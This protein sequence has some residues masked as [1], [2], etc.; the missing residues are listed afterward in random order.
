MLVTISKRSTPCE[1]ASAF[2][3]RI[4][5][6]EG[7]R[8]WR[9]DDQWRVGGG[10]QRQRRRI[11][12][13]AGVD[14][15]MVEA[16]AVRRQRVE[17]PAALGGRKGGAAA[18]A[19]MARREGQASGTGHD[20]L[21]QRAAAGEHVADRP[22]RIQSEQD[23][24]IGETHV[25]IEQKRPSARFGQGDGEIDAD[26]GLSDAALAARDGDRAGGP[27]GKQTHLRYLR[28]KHGPLDFAADHGD[29]LDGLAV[30]DFEK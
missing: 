9:D 5:V 26:I 22:G 2:T 23:T 25:A 1:T 15:D 20:Q 29:D 14:H 7:G 24:G 30:G 19:A 10:D 13:R 17:Q 8:L 18:G 11:D 21:V 12:A 6:D 27:T 4:S 16:R 3:K 28:F